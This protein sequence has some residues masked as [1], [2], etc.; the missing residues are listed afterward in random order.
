MTILRRTAAAALLSLATL[1]GCSDGTGSDPVP[2]SVLLT[3]AP[4]DVVS[5][6][7]TID[8]IYLQGEG[9]RTVLRDE[10]VTTDLV[11]LANDVAELVDGVEVPAGLYQELRFVISGGYI[12]VEE[13]G[14]EALY[15]SS[16]DYEGLPA[17]AVVDGSL[18]MPSYGASGLKVKFDGGLDVSGSQYVV[19]VDFD[20]AQSFGHAAGGDGW[21]MSPVVQGAELTAT[22]S[23][24]ASLTL[25]GG[26]TLPAPGG[27]AVTLA[28]FAAVLTHEGGSQETLALEDAD[29]DGTY[30]AEFAYLLPGAYQVEFAAPAGVTATYDPAGPLAATVSSGA[31]AEAAAEVVAAE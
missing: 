12:V 6:V 17:G 5:A 15:A 25:G 9:G 21:V 1:T 31:T 8:E 27:T 24:E 16:E 18:Q 28:D 10:P 19:L 22:G 11:T 3:D 26:V 2:V 7:V 29:G 4:G 30:S 23:V 13:E 14:G 20:V